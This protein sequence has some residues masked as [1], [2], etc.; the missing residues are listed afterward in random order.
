M[1]DDL[2]KA[3]ERIGLQDIKIDNLSITMKKT[4]E[5]KLLKDF[6]ENMPNID[7][8]QEALKEVITFTE[9]YEFYGNS[10]YVDMF[11]KIQ[12]FIDY[13]KEVE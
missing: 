12:N 10:H 8:V 7:E 3:L 1:R 5:F 2:L 4:K 13:F 6:F 9:S 11:T